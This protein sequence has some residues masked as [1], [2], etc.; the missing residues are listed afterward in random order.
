MQ[1]DYIATQEKEDA[2]SGIIED[3]N[4]LIP[5]NFK[6]LTRD[7]QDRIINQVIKKIRE[8]NIFPI[9]YYNQEG[10]RKEI[11]RCIKSNPV[12]D[13]N[14]ENIDIRSYTGQVFLDFMFPNLFTSTQGKNM[15]LYDQFYNETCLHTIFRFAFKHEKISNM[16]NLFIRVGRLNGKMPT[17]Y[18]PM[19]AKAIYECFCPKNGVIY[20]YSCG[21]GARMLGALSSKN[22][23][24]YIGVEPCTE[25]YDN[26]LNLGSY[27]EQCT[28]RKNSY[29]IY[30]ECSENHIEPNSS[31]DFIFSCPPFFNLEHYSTEDTQSEIKFANYDN[32]VNNY[33]YNTVKNSYDMLKTGGYFAVDI[34]NYSD[35]S[36]N[37]YHITED[38]LEQLEK[39]G[40]KFIKK[41]KI[42]TNG[43]KGRKKRQEDYDLEFL[44]LFQK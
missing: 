30:K 44:Y 22:N 24:T 16:R 43:K 19:R 10:I 18:N 21:F 36:K 20:D 11:L 13:F 5:D 2:Y 28:N 31:V 25:T 33:V 3:L 39:V 32:W 42:G 9:Y 34:N 1:W 12:M 23:Y 8:I 26:L 14:A 41:Y 4:I 7:E 6:E 17:N 27:I 29:K 15:S 37:Y 35:E 40:F 38:W